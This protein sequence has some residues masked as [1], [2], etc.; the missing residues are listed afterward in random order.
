MQRLTTGQGT[1]G[2]PGS[3][4]WDLSSAWLWTTQGISD[5]DVGGIGFLLVTIKALGI[6]LH[7][8]TLRA[9]CPFT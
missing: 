8:Q 1:A 7:E 6:S 3:R 5:R 9:P 2:F 4:H